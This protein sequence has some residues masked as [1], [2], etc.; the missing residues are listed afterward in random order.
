MILLF[1][2]DLKPFKGPLEQTFKK[3]SLSVVTYLLINRSILPGSLTFD[4]TEHKY[5]SVV[6]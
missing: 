5:R 4:L 3:K 6:F 2:I 1:L